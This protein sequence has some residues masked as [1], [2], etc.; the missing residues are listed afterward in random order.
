M[1]SLAR[2]RELIREAT[3]RLADAGIASPEYDAA[4]LLAHVLD[5]TRSRLSLVDEVGHEQ[6]AKFDELWPGEQPVN[7][8]ST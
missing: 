3:A 8:C 4:E 1:P 2:S 5:T 6:E 7:P